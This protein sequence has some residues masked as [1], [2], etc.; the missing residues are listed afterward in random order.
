MKSKIHNITLLL[1][2]IFIFSCSSDDDL[3]YQS[4]FENSQN[5]WLNFKE[6]SSNSYKYVVSGGS[7]FTPYGWE[8]T[9]TVSNGIVIQRHFAFIGN[10][11][12]IPEGQIG[13]TENENELNSHESSSAADDLTLDEIYSKAQNDWLIKRKH[14][15]TY[16]E[17][18]NNE[19]ISICGYVEKECFDDC[20]VGIKIK[21]IEVL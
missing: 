15:T 7:V 1:I 20:F 13:W 3:N 8:T 19:L 18:K 4:D 5:A 21:S 16:F 14:T 6:S 10:P 9:I 12:N 2:S 17:S 11:E